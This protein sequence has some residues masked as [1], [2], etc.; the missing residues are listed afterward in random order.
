MIEA[1]KILQENNFNR[2]EIIALLITEPP[3]KWL[4]WAY[5]LSEKNKKNN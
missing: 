5:R 4:K 3:Q 1:I 2:D